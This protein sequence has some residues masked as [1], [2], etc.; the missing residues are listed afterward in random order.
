[1]VTAQ[2]SVR[3]SRPEGSQSP[4]FPA[5]LLTAEQVADLLLLNVRT[6]RRMAAL[7]DLPC[8]RI[9]SRLR[10]DPSDITRWVSARKEGL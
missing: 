6:V 9:G 5:V 8:V 2:E 10:F 4:V 3:A 7:G 1:M